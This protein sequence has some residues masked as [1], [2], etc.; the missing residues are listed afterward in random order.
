[1]PLRYFLLWLRG[2]EVGNS[3]CWTLTVTVPVLFALGGCCDP[4]RELLL[5]DIGGSL[6]F[7]ET[8]ATCLLILGALFGHRTFTS[9]S[10]GRR[11]MT[12]QDSGFLP[13]H[14][15]V[16]H[17]MK[18]VVSDVLSRQ[19]DPSVAGHDA[20]V[21]RFKLSQSWFQGVLLGEPSLLHSSG[22]RRLKWTQWD[23]VCLGP[24]VHLD[25]HGN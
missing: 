9:P 11:S 12:D 7:L 15:V 3:S 4:E 24:R 18:L 17:W 2:L 16:P 8:D 22:N 10:Q 21:I 14:H 20:T 23:T 1:M 25:F 5:L 19:Y 13:G 6:A